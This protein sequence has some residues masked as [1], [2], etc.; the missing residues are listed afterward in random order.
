MLVHKIMKLLPCLLISTV[1]QVAAADPSLVPLL[2]PTDGGVRKYSERSRILT[3]LDG[4]KVDDM[5]LSGGPQTFGTMGGLWEVYLSRNGEF[6]RVGEIWAHPK[7]IAIEP[8]QARIHKDP[9]TR[10]YARIWVYLKSGGSAGGFG[11]YRVGEDSIDEMKR[12][13]IYPGDG[14]TVL[15]NAIYEATFKHSPIP[16]TIAHSTT[17]DAG[18]VSWNETKR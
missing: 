13:E 16:F 2:N 18:K 6:V 10:R 17:D 7:A 12:I 9:K 5:L 11:Y 8:D 14:G 1:L 4:D 3:D 15:G